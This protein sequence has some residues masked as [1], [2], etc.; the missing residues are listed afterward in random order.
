VT[1][2]RSREYLDLVYLDH[3]A[4]MAC[5]GVRSD[6]RPIDPAHYSGLMAHRLGKGG[7][8]KSFDI[9]SAPL[10]RFCHTDWDT[11]VNG[12]SDARALDFALWCLQWLH[13][14]LQLGHITLTVNSHVRDPLASKCHATAR[15]ELAR[16]PTRAGKKRRGSQ[17]TASSKTVPRRGLV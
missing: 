6:N 5:G 13:T 3:A 12:N 16:K 2:Y 17:C 4:C 8:Q 7:A 14:N 15:Q 9:A 11:Y 1:P 10:C